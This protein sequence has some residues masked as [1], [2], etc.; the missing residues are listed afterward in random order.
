MNPKR[1]KFYFFSILVSFPLLVSY[2]LDKQKIINIINQLEKAGFHE[3]AEKYRMLLEQSSQEGV[4]KV[5]NP[6]ENLNDTYSGNNMELS[7]KDKEDIENNNVNSNFNNASISI[8]N[9]NLE[10]DLLIWKYIQKNPIKAIQILSQKEKTPQVLKQLGIAYYNLGDYINAIKY[11]KAYMKSSEFNQDKDKYQ[12]LILLAYAYKNIFNDEAFKKYL[13]YVYEH[14]PELLKPQDKIA[15]AYTYLSE[16]ELKK[17]HDLINSLSDKDLKN[18]NLKDLKNL[19]ALYYIKLAYKLLCAK[20]Y[21]EAYKATQIAESLNPNLKELQELKAWLYLNEGN[22]AKAITYFRR[23]I[24]Y[25][26]DPNLF[27]GLALAYSKLDRKREAIRFLKLAE[28]GADRLLM[29]KIAN[30]YYNLGLKREA[31]RIIRL[32]ERENIGIKYT[33]IYSC[34]Y[35]MYSSL[36]DFYLKPIPGVKYTFQNN[37]LEEDISSN[38]TLNNEFKT[39]KKY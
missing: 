19:Y 34:G 11:L 37:S 18:I 24:Q 20:K 10:E 17:F 38:Y 15:L 33:S 22:Y 28:K 21:N 26:K 32:L 30:L 23:I 5:Q 12:I 1:I 31:L 6:M 39:K 27:Y 16:D 36:K 2:S 8:G 7:N 3:E 13:Q 4:N 14:K 35:Y 9:N 29:Y 25:K